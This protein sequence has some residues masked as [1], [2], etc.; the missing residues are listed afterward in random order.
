MVI[1]VLELFEWEGAVK[2][3]LFLSFVCLNVSDEVYVFVVDVVRPFYA[4]S[5]WAWAP[6][7][8]AQITQQQETLSMVLI[9]WIYTLE[10]I[11]I[12]IISSVCI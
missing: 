3:S 4:S 2:D 1:C 9:S 6:A 7:G 11:D 8:M 5:A 12:D 10:E